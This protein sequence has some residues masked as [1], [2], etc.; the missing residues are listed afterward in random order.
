[1]TPE[2]FAAETGLSLVQMEDIVQRAKGP[3]APGRR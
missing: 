2:Q 1:M 3:P